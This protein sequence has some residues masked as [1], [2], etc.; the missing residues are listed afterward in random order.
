MLFRSGKQIIGF[1]PRA[2]ELL[3]HY[4]WPN[5]YT[6]FKQILQ[7]LATYAD[8]SYIRGSAV[9]E[10]L[11]REQ[12]VRRTADRP[13]ASGF[14]PRPL[15]EIIQD[16]VSQTLEAQGGNQTAAARELGISRTTLWRYLR[17]SQK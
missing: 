11:T 15:Y 9:S 17:A 5:N 2:A 8:A 4:D 3:I 13:P 6:Q 7:E 16:A 14:V 12:A 1:D 10:I